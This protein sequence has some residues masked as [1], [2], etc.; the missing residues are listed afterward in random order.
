MSHPLC[1]AATQ[2][3]SSTLYQCTL[4]QDEDAYEWL[5]FCV[6]YFLLRLRCPWSISTKEVWDLLAGQSP[7]LAALSFQSVKKTSS[8]KKRFWS[9]QIKQIGRWLQM[10]LFFFFVCLFKEKTDEAYT[11]SLLRKSLYLP[12]DRRKAIIENCKGIRVNTKGYL[13]TRRSFLFW[14]PKLQ[15]SLEN[16]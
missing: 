16:N 6:F 13:Y 11:S 12:T 10:L 1:F 3:L 9:D 2:R 14:K 4:A 7:L 8:H 15:D 5:F